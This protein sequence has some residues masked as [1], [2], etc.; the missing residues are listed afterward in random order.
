M[1]EF[2]TTSFWVQF[3]DSPSVLAYLE[4]HF[5]N[6]DTLQRALLD[7][8]DESHFSLH[9]WV[10]ALVVLS[11]W[12]EVHGLHISLEDNIGYVSCAA[13]SAGSGA[14]L[15]HLPSLVHDLLDQ[16]GCERAVKK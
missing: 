5:K 6:E 8:A 3:A 9:Q 16:Y 14:S 12:L 1:Q 15:S 7:E 2:E 11:Q 4:A 10:E 13:A